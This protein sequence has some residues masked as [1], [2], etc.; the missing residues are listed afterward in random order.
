[1]KVIV[2]LTLLT[3]CLC[4]KF[5]INTETNMF[6]DPDGRESFFRGYNVVY[7]RFPFYPILDHFDSNLSFSR[8]DMELLNDMGMNIIRLG[9]QWPALEPQRGQ[10]NITYLNIMKDLV[11]RM[12]EYNLYALLDFHQ[13]NLSPMFCGEGI[14]LWA[15][16]PDLESPDRDFPMPLT[17]PWVTGPDKVPTDE[18]CSK[19]DWAMYTI[20]EA[21]SSAY[22]SLYKNRNGTLDAFASFW[23]RVATEFKDY[24][25]VMGYDL[26]NEPFAGDVTHHPTLWLPGVADKENLAPVYEVLSAAIRKADPEALIFFESTTWSDFRVGFDQVPGG[27]QYRNRSVLSYHYYTPPQFSVH[28]LW[29]ARMNDLKRLK[30]GGMLTEFDISPDRMDNFVEIFSSSTH[31]KQSW[32]G[33]EYKPYV[34]ITGFGRS[35]FNDDGTINQPLVKMVSQ[36]WAQSVAGTITHQTFDF[37]NGTYELVYDVNA[38]CKLPTVVYVSRERYYKNKPVVKIEGGVYKEQGKNYIHIK[39]EIG[40]KQVKLLITTPI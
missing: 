19:Y 28:Q 24:E 21:A 8:E 33:W 4:S 13:D 16:L 27:D 22:Q 36:T 37:K 1:M 12:A 26:I 10:Y 9:I 14:P 7:K 5:H 20:T 2:L 17:S 32:I 6:I 29:V 30:C 34:R 35:V 11:K 18:Q 31:F 40:S 3:A 25:N 15:T 39:N 23:Y 38:N